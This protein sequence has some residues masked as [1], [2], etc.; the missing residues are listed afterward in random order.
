MDEL[1]GFQLPPGGG[2]PGACGEVLVSVRAK[3]E[4]PQRKVT[5]FVRRGR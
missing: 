2:E 1:T 5:K 4:S 3:H